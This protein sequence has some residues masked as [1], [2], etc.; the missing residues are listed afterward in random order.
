MRGTTAV[1][2]K[3]VQPGM[4][5]HLLEVNVFRARSK[6]TVPDVLCLCCGTMTGKHHPDANVRVCHATMGHG[7]RTVRIHESIILHARVR[8]NTCRAAPRVSPCRVCVI[9]SKTVMM[10]LMNDTARCHSSQTNM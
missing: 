6:H 9:A 8:I 1:D 4:S 5:H 3:V 2:V 7:A 10:V